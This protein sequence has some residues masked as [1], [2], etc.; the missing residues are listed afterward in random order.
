MNF[1]IQKTALV[2]VIIPAVIACL[3]ACTPNRESA[4]DHASSTKEGSMN[5]ASHL[6]SYPPVIPALDKSAPTVFETAAFGLG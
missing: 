1:S 5:L 3:G 2:I 6:D 4:S